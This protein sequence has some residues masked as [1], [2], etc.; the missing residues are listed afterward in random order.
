MARFVLAVLLGA[1]LFLCAPT[2]AAET[3]ELT[4]KD[5]REATTRPG[6][7][8]YFRKWVEAENADGRLDAWVERQRELGFSDEALDQAQQES[9]VIIAIVK[10]GLR[11]PKEGL[12]TMHE[13]A[14]YGDPEH[15][16]TLIERGITNINAKDEDGLT[17]LHVAALRG[18]PAMVSA[19][20]K[21][22]AD[23]L[24]KHPEYGWTPLDMAKEGRERTEDNVQPYY[25]V[26]KILAAMEHNIK[27]ALEPQ[28]AQPKPRKKKL[29]RELRGGPS[30]AP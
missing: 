28:R 27:R 23:P 14:R 5:Y 29:R 16:G 15:V 4:K 2:W 7:W 18:R 22:G 17:P 19:L 26:I 6:F 3:K 1:A 20:I 11:I 30:A 24:A 8:T 13:V 25:D 21:F 12:P 10:N 9:A